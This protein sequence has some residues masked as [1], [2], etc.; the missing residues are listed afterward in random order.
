MEIL[1]V[2][3]LWLLWIKS[4][5]TFSYLSFSDRVHP[6]L[7]VYYSLLPYLSVITHIATRVIPTV[8]YKSDHAIPLLK[9]LQWLSII[10]TVKSKVFITVY[11]ALHDLPPHVPFCFLPTLF[12]VVSSIPLPF[13]SHSALYWTLPFE[14][15]N[16]DTWFDPVL[17]VAVIYMDNFNKP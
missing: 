7:L 9:I 17:K 1:V 2:S 3:S 14:L 5:E 6:F 11:K 16:Q 4:L 10:I 13:P 15:G 12:S 8:K